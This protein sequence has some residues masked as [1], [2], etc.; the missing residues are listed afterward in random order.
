MCHFEL[1]HGVQWYISHRDAMKFWLIT[2]NE[3]D[4]K[5]KYFEELFKSCLSIIKDKDFVAELLTLI[6]EP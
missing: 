2:P 1:Q 3:F 4:G 6:E 5:G